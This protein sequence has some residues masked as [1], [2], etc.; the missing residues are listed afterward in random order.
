MRTMYRAQSAQAR[1]PQKSLLT[2]V[3]TSATLSR[4]VSRV[5]GPAKVSSNLSGGAVGLPLFTS[6]SPDRSFMV[7]MRDSGMC[8]TRS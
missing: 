2:D 4:T 3:R 5:N 7:V 1:D 8:G 6:P